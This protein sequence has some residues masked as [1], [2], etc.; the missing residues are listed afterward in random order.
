M[1]ENAADK[2]VNKLNSWLF[3]DGQVYPQPTVVI[4]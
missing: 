2:T 1:S 3:R 4:I